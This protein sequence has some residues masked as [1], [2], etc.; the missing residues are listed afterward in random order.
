MLRER[1]CDEMG[2]RKVALEPLV[3]HLNRVPAGAPRPV[4]SELL[5]ILDVK[6]LL[7]YCRID[8]K[9]RPHAPMRGPDFWFKSRQYWLR[10]F[11]DEFVDYLFRRHT[12][13]QWSILLRKHVTI[14]VEKVFGRGLQAAAC[15]RIRSSA[16]GLKL[17]EKVREHTKQPGISAEG[18]EHSGQAPPKSPPRPACKTHPHRDQLFFSFSGEECVP[19]PLGKKRRP[20]VKDLTKIWGTADCDYGA[21]NTAVL[22]DDIG[23]LRLHPEN[24]IQVRQLKSDRMSPATAEHALT[25]STKANADNVSAGLKFDKDETLPWIALYLEHVVHAG[26]IDGDVRKK[27]RQLSFPEFM[28]ANADEFKALKEQIGWTRDR[29]AYQAERRLEKWRE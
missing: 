20:F 23:K 19:D 4:K 26:V 9:L 27:I 1:A 11:V 10:P 24:L 21:T 14:P 5:V 6:A 17:I 13:G 22:D 25:L 8:P 29:A 16:P 2:A 15:L 18:S 28:K 12:V 3:K 7:R